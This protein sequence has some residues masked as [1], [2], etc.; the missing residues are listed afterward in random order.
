MFVTF[1]VLTLALY[2]VEPIITVYIAQLSRHAGPVALLAGMT[3]SASGLASIIAAPRLGRLSD[4][5][6]PHKVMLVALIVAGL[7][8]IPQAFSRTPGS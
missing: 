6:G 3:F 2:S 8:I 4:R 5:I 1:F 7:I